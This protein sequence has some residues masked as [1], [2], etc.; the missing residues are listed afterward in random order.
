VCSSSAEGVAPKGIL[1]DTHEFFSLVWLTADQV[2]TARRSARFHNRGTG[3]VS[4]TSRLAS[5]ILLDGI[6][7]SARHPALNGV[8]LSR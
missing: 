7:D 4:V 3:T 5:S 8:A 2:S 6:S 1:R